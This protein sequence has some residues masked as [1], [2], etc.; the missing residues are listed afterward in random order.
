MADTSQFQLPLLS[1]AQAQKH[2]TVNEALA[3][4]DCV[5]QLRVLDTA[6]TLPPV[7][8]TEGDA[9][10]VAAGAGGDWFGYDGQ[11]AIAVNGGWRP[12]A[13][14]AGW[15]CFNVST[16]T[17]LLYDGTEWLDST[18]AATPTGAATS[19]LITETDFT[20][21]AGTTLTTNTMIPSHSLV[22]GVTARVLSDVTGTLTAW[23]LGDPS[24]GDRFATGL[25]LA[26]G[27]YALGMSNPPTAYYA[28]TGLVLTGEGGDFAGGDIRLAVHYM[29]LSPPRA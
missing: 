20:L 1:A 6:L 13:P 10:L 17:H 22:F 3:V 9:Y 29:R 26:Q 4:L 5:S 27:S 23:R 25:G 15:Q 11:L 21:T 28:D 16:G 19:F 14:K 18:L 7:S 2:V 12:V 8:A 24:G